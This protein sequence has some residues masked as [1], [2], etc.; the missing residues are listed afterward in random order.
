MFDLQGP[1]LSPGERDLLGHPAAG[2]VILFTRNY[3]S[4]EQLARLVAEIHAVRDPPL[5]VAVDHEGG[6]V[7]RFRPGFTALPPCAA[8]GRL[9]DKDP[10]RARTM[11]REYGWLMAIELRTL[12]VDFSFA[13]V[14]DLG[15]GVS[16]VIGD[17]AFHPNPQTVTRLAQAYLDGMHEAGTAGVGKH[18]PGHGSV[19]ADSHYEIPVDCRSFE[20]ITSADLAPF[21]GLVRA[22]LDAIMPAHVVYP[23]VDTAPASFSE[24]WLG[25][26][27]RKDLGFEGAIFSDDIDMAGARGIGIHSERAQRA[28]AA[29][30]D[31]VIMCNRPRAL[32]GVLD[33]L[34]AVREPLGEARLAR[35]RGRTVASERALEERRRAAKAS[36]AALANGGAAG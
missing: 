8:L 26:V 36:V 23:E 22:G 4:R 29:G 12:G 17:R 24:V 13:P 16:Q 19:A 5:L 34:S 31:M 33:A 2:G 20:A 15:S 18:F 6:R 32:P 27:L 21:A 35:M 10:Q 25:Q 11:A 14:L 1:E 28:L 9:D 30:C 3:I 7:Q